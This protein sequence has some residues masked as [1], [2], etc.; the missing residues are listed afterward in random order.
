MV[1]EYV[2]IGTSVVDSVEKKYILGYP[3][4]NV[5]SKEL[6]WAESFERSVKFTTVEKAVEFLQTEPVLNIPK[7]IA[8]GTFALP[9]LL[10]NVATVEIHLISTTKVDVA[11]LGIKTPAEI[12]ALNDLI[13]QRNAISSQITELM[14]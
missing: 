8:D 4:D 11:N 14:K 13:I 3:L 2:I 9:A 6:V 7:K 1:N 10:A 5:Y 12:I